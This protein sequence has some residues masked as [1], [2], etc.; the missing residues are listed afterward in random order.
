MYQKWKRCKYFPTSLTYLKCYSNTIKPHTSGWQLGLVTALLWPLKGQVVRIMDGWI[1]Q[2][3]SQYKLLLQYYFLLYHKDLLGSY[4]LHV[5]YTVWLYCLY[6]N[7]Y[8]LRDR[9]N[10]SSFYGFFFWWKIIKLKSEVVKA[11]ELS[12]KLSADT[13]WLTNNTSPSLKPA[14][15]QILCC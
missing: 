9:G 2:W 12:F 3:V 5:P 6:D 10:T 4:F 1:Y 14:S 11:L 15:C 7:I 8:V 13:V